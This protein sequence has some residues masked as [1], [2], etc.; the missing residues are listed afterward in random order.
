MPRRRDLETI[1]LIGSGP[2][3]IGQAC[4]FDYAG[5]QALKVLREDGFRT[6]VV[7]SNPA[8]IMTDPGFADRTYLE[9]LDVDA[10]GDVLARERP[11]ALL[12]T[13]G[14]Q[15]ALNLARELAEAGILAE[16]G[17]ELIGA[18]LDVIKRAEDRELFR[19]AVRAVGLQVPGSRIV[20][21]VEEL[22]G[23][24]LPAVVRPAFTLGGHGGGF[25]ETVDQLY[26]QVELGIGESPIGQ[27]LVEESVRGWDEFELEVVRDRKD[28]VVIVCSIENID[29]MG[30]HTGDSV[31][32][33]PQMTLSD[34]AYQELRDA[35]AAVVRAVGVECGGSNIQFARERDT[36]ELRVIEMN[37]R[38]SRSSALASKATGYPIAKVAAKLAVGYTLDEIPN[39]LTG[40]TPASFEPTLDYVVVKFP[41]FAFEKFPGADTTLGTQMKSVGEAMGI[42]RTFTEAYLKAQR[43]RELDADEPWELPPGAHPWFHAEL[44][45]VPFAASSLDDLVADDFLRLKRAGLSDAEIAASC[46]TTEEAVRARRRSWGVRPAYRRVDSCAGEVEAAS[47]YYYSTWGEADEAAP[48]GTAPR[49]VILGSGPNRIGQGIEFDYCCVHAAQ[50]FRALGYEA[51]MVNCNPETVST[52]Y[53][54]SDRLYFEPLGL[55][56]VLAVCERE[57]PEGVAIQFGGQTP[58]K[59]A[60]GLEQA[61]YRIMGTPFDAVDLAEDR[62]RFGALLDR[63]G[64]R[65][66]EWGIARTGAEARDLAARIG[67]P[68]LIRPSYVLGGRAMRVCYS[69]DDIGVVDRPV[70]I[71]RFLE[72]AI[73]ID[74]D[75]VSDGEDTFVGAVM[76]H[77]EEA[78]VHS[79]DSACV[80]PAP[81]LRK[82][83]D[84]EIRSIVRRL[85]RALGVVGLLNVQLAV[86]DGTVYVLEANPRASRTVPF[87]SKATGVNL[88]AA[89]C[90]AAAGARLGELELPRERRPAQVSV[91]AAV[92]PFAR[93]PGADPVLGPE[94]RATGEVMASAGDL[95]TAFAKAERAAGRPLPTSGTAFLSVRDADKPA[96]VYVAAALAD[97][98]FNLLATAGT[99]DTLIEAGLAVERVRKVTED[100]DGPTVVDLIRRGRCNL[101]VNTPHGS[102]ARTDGYLIREAALVARVPCIT[103]L[104]GAAAAVHAIANARSEESLSLQERIERE[105][106]AA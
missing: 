18:P 85:A 73:E 105:T 58:L 33:A 27:V 101:V 39:D 106:R 82:S 59:L 84:A 17:V 22:G 81:S 31:T 79:G 76:Q 75:A 89:A 74:V 28:N 70:L 66:P 94:M 15:T 67:Y 87:A 63:L 52:D 2:I 11:D 95:P 30:V 72:S 100:G 83:E 103:T 86:V 12:P 47:T 37:P 98:G 104:S 60:R 97:L 34:H 96:V 29:P 57:Q 93:F 1:C 91:K 48:T 26:R 6:I 36:G 24:S 9:P 13:M 50:S 92:L 88:V 69:A 64:I 61:G 14:G 78:G 51:V 10:V 71:D 68:V 80:L 38:V 54:T 102:G 62:E 77:V 42:G 43:S 35:A 7:N 56:E 16:L 90:R 23:I 65:C 49:V 46:A 20:T 5:C 21:E 3:V 45:R 32:V 55:E 99:A 25:V 19:D 40:T 8:T 41:R 44:E 53:D 4:E